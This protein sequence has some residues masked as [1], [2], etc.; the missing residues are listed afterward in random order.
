LHELAAC[1]A[2]SGGLAVTDKRH[3]S[4]LLVDDDATVVRALA[5]ILDEFTPMRFASSGTDALRLSR[6]SAP[7]L[8]LLDVELPDING[9]DLCRMFKSE[10]ALADVPIMFMTSHDSLQMETLGLQ[11]GAVDFI[12]K[13]PHAPLVAARVR[14]HHRMKEMSE[15]LTQAI[16]MDY[17]TGT[18]NR[19]RLLQALNQECLRARRSGSPFALL[20]M[21]IDAL[22]VYRRQYGEHAQDDCLRAVADRLRTLARRPAD[23]LA[24]CELGTFGLLLPETSAAG[25]L[26]LSQ[27][28]IREIDAMNIANENSP[29]APHVTLTVGIASCDRIHVAA[30]ISN[31]PSLHTHA[32]P[33]DLMRAAKHAVDTAQGRGGHQAVIV[34]VS[35]WR[36][37]G[38]DAVLQ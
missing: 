36:S 21:S 34:N 38:I 12:S 11:I 23:L 20:L 19:S 16:S 29:S 9:F 4:I 28:A 27:R 35:T 17:L 5:R 6:E 1:A 24:H 30:E 2:R 13:P 10:V 7:D 31:A 18:A 25:A 32:M 33:D 37:A 3:F 8:V 22:D 14:T 26:A 15:T